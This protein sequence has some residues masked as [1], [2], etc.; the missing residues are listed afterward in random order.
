MINYKKPFFL[1]GPK[2]FGIIKRLSAE[3]NVRIF[4]P[5]F[6]VKEQNFSEA[7]PVSL[8]GECVD[9]QR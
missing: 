7:L 6:N 5:E 9:V 1:Y 8:E 3:T 4:F 2:K